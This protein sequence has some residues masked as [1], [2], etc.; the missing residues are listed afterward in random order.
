MGEA[1]WPTHLYGRL[2]GRRGQREVKR[3]GAHDH[4]D[5][6]SKACREERRGGVRL[7]SELTEATCSALDGPTPT[8]TLGGTSALLRT[9]TSS[10]TDAT[11]P[12]L[13]Q[14]PATI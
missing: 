14:L 12:L 6:W 13:F 9:D 1:R 8:S 3:H 11:V 10:R 7:C 2:E 5:T 4:L